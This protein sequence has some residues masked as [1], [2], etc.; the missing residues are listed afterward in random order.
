MECSHL[1]D[2]VAIGLENGEIVILNIKKDEI[3]FTVKQKQTVT[4]IGFCR[5]EPWMATGDIQGNLILWDLENKRILFKF[6]DAFTCS[7]D[8]IL[9]MPGYP[10]LTAGSSKSN[11]I[12]Q[13]KINLDDSKVLTLHRERSGHLHPLLDCKAAN[14]NELV[15]RTQHETVF[16]SL[17]SQCNSYIMERALDS[18][19]PLHLV[20]SHFNVLLY[21][22]QTLTKTYPIH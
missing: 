2:I 21:S 19:L 4:S 9:F 16:S 15:L 13:F 22:K 17:Y 3:I 11:A 7:V 14:N 18:K 6:K 8:S 12:K 10:I 5:E 20:A 1:V